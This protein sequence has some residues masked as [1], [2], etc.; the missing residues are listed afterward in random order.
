M[1]ELPSKLTDPSRQSKINIGIAIAIGFG[2]GVATRNLAI[3]VVLGVAL[4]FVL[5]RA[6]GNNIKTDDSN[7]HE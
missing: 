5:N 2:I 4:Y 6:K 7:N 3:S 1:E